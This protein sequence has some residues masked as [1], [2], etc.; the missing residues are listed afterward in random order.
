MTLGVTKPRHYYF[1][2]FWKTALGKSTP[3]LVDMPQI[4]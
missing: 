4:R 3:S 1:P 2:L